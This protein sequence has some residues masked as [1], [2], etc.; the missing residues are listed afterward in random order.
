MENTYNAIIIDD[1][2]HARA[3]L[4]G[5]IKENINNVK[6][7]DEA[8]DLPSG[9]ELIKT[10]QPDIVFLDIE[11]PEYSGLEI[12]DFF[13]DETI[14]FHIIFVT[15]YNQY[16][17]DAFNLS[18]I[19]YLVKPIN[20]EDLNR[21]LEKINKITSKNIAALRENLNENTP[22]KLIL[23]SSGNQLFLNLDDII[24]IKADG[25][26]SNV[27][28]VN[29]ERHCVTKRISEFDKLQEI[30]SFHR[31]HRSQ[32]INSKHISCISKK[33]GGTITMI[34]GDE[35]GITKEKRIELEQLTGHIRI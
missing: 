15:A 30:G 7:I 5:I 12:L 9:V 26:Y 32:I 34:N 35:L 13:E 27:I 25:S 6:I 1:E 16:A 33:D 3:A 11:M 14:N 4:K 8:K 23:N 24:Y 17:L 22:P 21:A 29:G 28:L 18:A 31:I 20:I 10:H 19:D 2:L